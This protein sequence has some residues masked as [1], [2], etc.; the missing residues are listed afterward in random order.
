MGFTDSGLSGAA[1][2]SVS[3]TTVGEGMG[4]VEHVGDDGAGCGQRARARPLE[5]RPPHEVAL[6]LD[7]VEDAVHLRQGLRLGEENGVNPNLD[8]PVLPL[9]HGQQLDGVAHLPGVA[10]VLGG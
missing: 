9:A 5:H 6:H 3:Q 10:E 1:S 8:L 7:G 4:R 2:G